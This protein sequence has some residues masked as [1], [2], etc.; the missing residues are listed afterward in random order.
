MG[1]ISETNSK[2]HKIQIPKK[3]KYLSAADAVVL[4]LE[5][6]QKD[7]D[8]FFQ[9][10][11]DAKLA[12]STLS[13]MQEPHLKKFLK[14]LPREQIITLFSQGSMDD[15]VYL[16]G[17]IDK[18]KELLEEIPIKQSNLLKKY[19]AYPEDSTGR[20]MQDDYF[21]TSLDATAEQVIDSLRE[22]SRNKFVHYIYCIDKNKTLLGV[23]S[24]RQLVIAP[25][26][27]KMEDL[28]NKNVVTVKATMKNKKASEVVSRYH[29]VSIPVV[30]DK[31]KML[32]MVT[33]DDILEVVSDQ[34]TAQIYAMA[35]LPENDHIY[36]NPFKTIKNRFPWLVVNLFFAV[37]ASSI[38]SMFEQT[39]SRLIILATLKNIVAGIGGNT[40]IQTLTVTTRG[41]EIGDFNFT[42]FTKALLKELFVG[43]VM[44]IL[45]GI[46]A[47]IITYIWKDSLLVAIVIF[48]AMFI[49]SIV[50]VLAGY[51]IPLLMKKLGKDPAVSGGVL[52]TITT[53]IFG[54]FI[55]LSIASIGLKL[56][57]EAL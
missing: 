52:V 17:F 24:I 21:S 1:L 19:M 16:I 39:M 54:F 55:F 31:N 45:M 48:I 20:I 7:A 40:A 25:S 42:T 34:A 57:G 51:T 33:V 35:G 6:N 2:N 36:T 43:A 44:G 41:L 26:Q 8:L 28:V 56:V 49:N 37:V 46:G 5:Y 50:A 27:T 32:G 53:D 15:L 11:L 10:L 3:L 22:Y 29:Y 47:G 12:A 23:L 13:E 9:E 14:K 18:K 38:I 4:L 30:D